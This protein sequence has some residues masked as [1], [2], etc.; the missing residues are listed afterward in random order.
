MYRLEKPDGK[1]AKSGFASGPTFQLECNFCYLLK[2]VDCA[3]RLL[4]PA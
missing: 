4:M 3:T 2:F 1:A